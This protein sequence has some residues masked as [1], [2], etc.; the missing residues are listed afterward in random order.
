MK[1]I[2]AL[3]SGTTNVKAILVDRQGNVLARYSVPLSIEY[4]KSGWVEQSAAG[5]WEAARKAVEGC[6]AQG[7]GYEVVALG[8]SNQRETLVAWNRETGKAAAPCIV[9]QCR[10]SAEICQ[11]LRRKGLEEYIR[12]KTG[13]QVDPL[14]PSSKIQWLLENRSDLRK[15]AEEGKLCLGTVDAWLVWNLTGG[16]RFVT[17][18]SNAS[19][20]QLFNIGHGAWDPD[21]LRL[22]GVPATALPEV[23]ASN[24]LL[25]E[26]VLSGGT[27]L[28]IY[29]ILGDSHAALLG[30]GVLETGKVKAT[31]GT[32]SSLMTL[33]D[34]P[35]G[36]EKGISST[37]AW[38]FDR[39][40][41]AYEGNITVTGSGLSWVLALAGFE[42]LEPAVKRATELEGSGDIYFVPALA[43]LG[44]PHWD[45]KARGAFVGLSFD[46]RKEHLVRAAL[47]AI[48]FQVKDVFDAME[49]AGGRLEALLADGGASKNDWLMQF[50]ADVLGRQVLRSQTAE[51]SGLGAAFAAGLGCGFWSSTEEI[52]R[53]VAPHDAFYPSLEESKRNRLV[54]RWN[55]AVASVKAYALAQ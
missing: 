29:G 4:P 11:A 42:D 5:V 14:F 21:L 47:E 34:V 33:C 7:A 15:L 28:P 20:T 52:A 9:W 30:H 17:D 46:T 8:I 26:A 31:Y 27:P 41:Y 3:D 25:G 54:S 45:D 18:F 35:E 19:R 2:L 24:E 49:R 40:Q 32:G 1:A 53:L 6:L 22:F 55:D 38:K 48:A 37:I 51:L 23:V 44:A 39:I 13:L 50:Q 12:T 43:G 16:K 36:S 10:R